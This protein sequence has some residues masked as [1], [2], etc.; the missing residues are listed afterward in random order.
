MLDDPNLP[1]AWHRRLFEFTVTEWSTFRDWNLTF[2]RDGKSALLDICNRLGDPSFPPSKKWAYLCSIPEVVDDPHAARGLITLGRSLEAPYAR[3][4]ADTLLNRFWALPNSEGPSRAA[5]PVQEFSL[6]FVAEAIMAR[7]RTGQKPSEQ[8][9]AVMNGVPFVDALREVVMPDDVRWILAALEHE[10][11]E[12]AGLFLS[13]LRNHANQEQVQEFLKAKWESATPF[14]RAHLLWRI[15]D[16]PN[17]P[18]VWQK[19]IFE[20]MLEKWETFQSVSLKFLGNSETIVSAAQE[21]YDDPSVPS[22]K[23]WA[24]LCRVASISSDPKSAKRFLKLG[25]KAEDEFA[26]R[27]AAVLLDRFYPEDK[28]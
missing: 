13:L 4:V 27:V 21:R 22:T 17:L 25:L 9:A 11:G 20:F 18:D 28:P 23:K 24:Y 3:E 16:D 19:R 7:L 10:S 1:D 12:V 26:R 8:E 5:Q 15:L 6:R 2:Y 14:L